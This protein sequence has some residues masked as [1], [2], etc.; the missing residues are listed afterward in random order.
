M[1]KKPA[2]KCMV[3]TIRHTFVNKRSFSITQQLYGARDAND[4]DK[5]TKTLDKALGFSHAIE[6]TTN[7]EN[8]K[9]DEDFEISNPKLKSNITNVTLDQSVVKITTINNP[10]SGV[11]KANSSSKEKVH[12]KTLSPPKDLNKLNQF[13]MKLMTRHERVKYQE[14][15]QHK[16]KLEKERVKNTFHNSSNKHIVSNN[17]KPHRVCS[18]LQQQTYYIDPYFEPQSITDT[19]CNNSNANHKPPPT[20][21][22]NLEKVLFQP[23][24]IHS[25]KDDRTKKYNFSPFIEKAVSVGYFNYDA[26]NKYTAPSEDLKL[27]EIARENNLKFYSSTSSM[28][29][30]LSH[31]H[32]LISNFKKV[33][34]TEITKHFNKTSARFT[35]G[36]QLPTAVILQKKK[37]GVNV[38]PS[39]LS[40]FYSITAEKSTDKEMILS[41]LGHA[42]EKQLTTDAGTFNK[43]YNK[44]SDRYCQ[45]QQ[46]AQTTIDNDS[47]HYMRIMDFVIRSQLDCYH[48]N[49]PGTGVFDLK[50]RAVCAIRHDLLYVEQHNN[51]TGYE[52][53]KLY[54]KFE[55]FERE[56]YDLCRSTLLKYS[57]QARMGNMDGIFV[58]YHNI[59]K[60]FGFQYLPLEEIDHIIHGYTNEFFN[61]K[62]DIRK[63]SIVE[64]WG[65]MEYVKNYDYSSL[66]KPISNK[67]ADAEF[68]FSMAI[69]NNVFSAII[70]LFPQ[71]DNIRVLFKCEMQK[72][73]LPNGET[74]IKPALIV[75]AIPI[76]EKETKFLQRNELSKTMLL[77]NKA[78]GLKYIDQLTAFNKKSFSDH[79]DE[80]VGFKITC[81][82]Y[83]NSLD[84]DKNEHLK[85]PNGYYKD[86]RT[87]EYPNFFAPEDVSK[88]V[89]KTEYD[90]V[91]S[92]FWLEKRYFK[93]LN[94]KLDTLR[95]YFSSES[96][97]YDG[98]IDDQS[99]SFP[100]KNNNS[101]KDTNKIIGK[102]KN[103]AT[104][105]ENIIA[106]KKDISGHITKFRNTLRAYSNKNKPTIPMDNATKNGEEQHKKN[107]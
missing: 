87:W 84:G 77:K 57:L 13:V 16:K 94:E 106:K 62:L 68:R 3:T 26:I 33:N 93:F 54:G 89:L 88:W 83:L 98:N 107:K 64:K 17:G 4:I 37:H 61:D 53:S 44:N 81:K 80:I 25:L 66:Q 86:F 71:V 78:G 18:N 7:Y 99:F 15:L 56:F 76:T 23:M 104:D 102:D 36:A 39:K 22:H 27:L 19:N 6:N 8:K 55:S 45:R 95:H 82:S 59:K 20:L 90:R 67:I 49:L 29:G 35:K 1:Y 47:F 52:I 46:H 91:S 96:E 14:E 48:K 105:R 97:S 92:T 42:L 69:L 2:P 85:D 100:I 5:T 65:E 101:N 32:F 51:T 24:V 40:P 28:T 12:N 30:I 72:N 75:I 63:N 60:I 11:F 38:G 21:K 58:A 10:N 70:K 34:L 74:V 50:T 43:F 73:T 31:L 9:F 41:Q 79:I 103:E